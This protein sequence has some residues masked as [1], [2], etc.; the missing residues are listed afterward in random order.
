MTSVKGLCHWEECTN[1]N[2]VKYDV[3]II[4]NL[5]IKFT[6]QPYRKK[7][8]RGIIIRW[9]TCINYRWVSFLN[10]IVF[11]PHGSWQLNFCNFVLPIHKCYGAVNECMRWKTWSSFFFPHIS[12]NCKLS[13]INLPRPGNQHLRN[14]CFHFKV[15]FIAAFEVQWTQPKHLPYKG[16]VEK[17]RQSHPSHQ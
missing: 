7:Q 15:T 3:D 6:S 17:Y 5:R 11:S 13:D 16:M 9:H 10:L 2:P 1:D 14:V 12:Y 4:Q 8:S